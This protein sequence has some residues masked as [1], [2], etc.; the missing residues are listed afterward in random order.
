VPGFE[1][2]PSP[3]QGVLNITTTDPGV[4]GIGFRAR[5]NERNLFLMVATGPL[6]DLGG[7]RAVFPHVVDGGGYATQFILV[8][9][10]GGSIGTLRFMDQSGNPLNVAISQ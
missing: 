1:N 6:R 3:F 7:Q 10:A 9:G 2:L 8:N 4:T 5:Y